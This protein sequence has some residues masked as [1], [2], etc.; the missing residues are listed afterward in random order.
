MPEETAQFTAEE[1]KQIE[2]AKDMG[3]FIRG[4]L[5]WRAAYF[6]MQFLMVIEGFIW[7]FM[8]I[9]RAKRM[10][11]AARINKNYLNFK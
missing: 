3:M 6:Y 7:S 11:V 4:S 8:D 9:T 10:K 1:K 5:K 2:Q